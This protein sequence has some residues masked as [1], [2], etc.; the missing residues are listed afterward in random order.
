MIPFKKEMAAVFISRLPEEIQVEIILKLP[1]RSILSCKCVC[2]LWFNLISSPKFI[3]NHLHLSIR[4]KNNHKLM[5]IDK[6]SVTGKPLMYSI[7]YS[8]ITSTP[9]L[10]CE[11]LG[12]EAIL[13]DYPFEYKEGMEIRILGA[14]NGLFCFYISTDT[15]ISIC[16]WNPTTKYK[17]IQHCDFHINPKH[18]SRAGF[19]YD[20]KTGDYKMVRIAEY[21]KSDYCKVEVYTFGLHS[22]KTVH[23]FPYNYPRHVAFGGVFLNGALHWVSNLWKHDNPNNIVSFDISNEKLMDVQLPE[24]SIMYPEDSNTRL[25]KKVGVL[26]D[27]LS[28]VLVDTKLVQAEVWVMQEYGARESWTKQFTTTQTP[29][30]RYPFCVPVMSLKHGEVLMYTHDGFV[31]WDPMNGRVGEVS[32]FFQRNTFRVRIDTMMVTHPMSYV[33]SLVSLN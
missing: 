31:L 24:K 33:D 14:C 3:N 21:Q 25:F 23:I 10:S 4:N 32:T 16:I 2:K 1:V 20:S 17:E 13:M 5:F 7:D 9:D 12:N 27:C 29:I 11:Y 30:T 22:S 19:G 28:L 8:S 26:G 18:S 6:E 15:E